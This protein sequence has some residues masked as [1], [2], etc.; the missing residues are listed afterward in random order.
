MIRASTLSIESLSVGSR[1]G[2]EVVLPPSRLAPISASDIVHTVSKH[3][4]RRMRLRRQ[5][6]G[7]SMSDL[8]RRM[9]GVTSRQVS[10]YEAGETRLNIGRLAQAARALEAPVDFFFGGMDSEQIARCGLSRPL[11]QYGPG[12]GDLAP[13]ASELQTIGRLRKLPQSVRDAINEVI[14]A[15]LERH[16]ARD[17]PTRQDAA[18]LVGFRKP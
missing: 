12:S 10:N 4:G 14:A 11:M 2:P 15:A 17:D 7:L 6:L 8:G 1:G 5:L 3:V 16:D 9:G 18:A 13:T